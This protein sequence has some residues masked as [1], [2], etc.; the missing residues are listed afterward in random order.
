MRWVSC[1]Y[2]NFSSITL[3]GLQGWWGEQKGRGLVQVSASMN[4]S[5]RNR[6][7]AFSQPGKFT[8][9][10]PGL[11]SLPV[12]VKASTKAPSATYGAGHLLGFPPSASHWPLIVFGLPP[13]FI[14]V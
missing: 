10:A 4:G 11:G 12:R 13:S 2:F 3:Y 6:K 9:A 14:E 1:D 8:L 5:Q 7:T